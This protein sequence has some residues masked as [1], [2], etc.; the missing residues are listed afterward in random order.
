MEALPQPRFTKRYT[1]VTEEKAGGATYTPKILADFV[2]QQI[3]RATL[4]SALATPICILDPAVG[5]GE[6]LA[7]LLEQLPKQKGLRME[8]YGFETNSKAINLATARLK[9]RFPE[10]SIHLERGNFLEF[11][12]EHCGEGGVGNL[13]RSK[14]PVAYDLIIANPPYVRTQVMGASQAQLLAQQFGLTGRVDLYY[15][16]LLGIAHVLKPR[17]IA[18]IIV[19]NRFMTTRSGMMVRRSI[20]EMFNIQHIWDLGDTKLFNAAVL[21]AVL[22]VEGKNGRK[23]KTPAFTSIYE[24][25][26]NGE[27]HACAVDPIAALSM[28]GPVTVVDGRCYLV[29]HGA[30]DTGGTLEGVWRIATREGD[31]WLETVEAHTWGVFR[32]IGNIRVGVKTCADKVFIRSDWQDMAE[33]ERP[34]LLRPLATHHI[35]R[36]FKALPPKKPRH[37]LYPHAMVENRR[38]AVDLTQYPRAKA[39]LE[40]HRSILRGRKYVLEAGRQW[41]EIW[42]PQDPGVWELPKLIFK[43]ISE[44]PTFWMDLEG[45]VVNGD[46]YWLICRKP[47]Q[48]DLLWLA[49]TVGNSSF[50]KVFY[51][52]RFH[53]KLYAGRRRFLTQY[54]EHF[55]LPD[56]CSRIGQT[57]IKKTKALYECIPSP[58]ADQLAKELNQL[59]WKAFGLVSEEI[60]G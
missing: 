23:R 9:Q 7:S 18:G 32:D 19:S 14:I 10:A 12:L 39:Y 49:A 16:F 55:P 3:V 36:H 59:V 60:H 43:D 6:L 58:C 4:K 56:P 13:F 35:A 38:Q 40:R 33:E 17:G 52:R 44:E 29:R 27:S 57:I 34:E 5:D 51:D 26:A 46:C 50:I 28:E 24:T 2:A 41:Y 54:V 48:S 37:I 21:P 22:L 42:V 25:T 1:L 8:V 20:R 47:G 11:V 15:P 45:T 53:N 31:A 30:L